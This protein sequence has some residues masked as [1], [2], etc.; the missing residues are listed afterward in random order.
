MIEGIHTM[1]ETLGSTPSTKIKFK[2]GKGSF[3]SVSGIQSVL[4]KHFLSS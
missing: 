1:L 4:N 2:L 3:L